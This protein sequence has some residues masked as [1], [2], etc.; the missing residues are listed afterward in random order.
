[1]NIIVCVKQV[2][3]TTEVRIDPETGRMIREGV[4][5][6]LNPD[7]A[8]A[9]EAALQIKDTMS[10]THISV[11]TMGPPSAKIVLYECLGMGADEA[12]LI[13][14]KAFGG[15]DTW[16]TSN[17]I[18]K[19]IRYI[20]NFDIVLTG[21]Q[22]IDGDTAQ[23]G[24]QTA[25]KLGIPQITYVK[26]IRIDGDK[27]TAHR[28][29]ANGYRIVEARMPVLLTAIGELNQPRLMN[30]KLIAQAFKYKEIK[31]LDNEKL[32]LPQ[33][34]IGLLASPTRVKK[35]FSPEMIVEKNVIQGAPKEA[36]AELVRKLKENNII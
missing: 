19:A 24:P 27:V 4:P 12:Y 25:E 2:P 18:A 31:Y 1:M 20:G 9:L 36:A 17:I 8:N 14:D 11:I 16:A 35:T 15:S 5:S 33:D 3:D 29:E 10:D 28:A 34:Q 26:G 6:I 21:R 30:V 22:A 32:E 23:V 13:T 7:D